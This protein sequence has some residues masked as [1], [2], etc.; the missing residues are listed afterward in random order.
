MREVFH[1]GR[2]L[3]NFMTAL[4]ISMNIGSALMM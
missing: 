2:R 4:G 1:D 3:M